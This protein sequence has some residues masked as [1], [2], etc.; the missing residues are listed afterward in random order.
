M[1]ILQGG[2]KN[3]EISEKRYKATQDSLNEISSRL[4][5]AMQMIATLEAE[6]RQWV[7]EKVKQTEIISKQLGN[8]DGVV[9][10]LQDEIRS[11][12]SKLCKECY[13]KV[14]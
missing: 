6:K 9:E 4:D 8:S 3:M 14:R 11:I 7:Q 2:I 10:Q 5:I 12:K 13:R 1:I